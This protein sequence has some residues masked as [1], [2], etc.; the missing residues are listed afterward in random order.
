MNKKTLGGFAATAMLLTGGLVTGLP[1]T[2]GTV[3]GSTQLSGDGPV[4]SEVI[5]SRI[6][7]VKVI[8][9]NN[10]NSNVGWD[11]IDQRSGQKIAN[12]TMKDK[13]QLVRKAKIFE[14]RQYKLR[15]RCQDPIWNRTNC[16][17]SGYVATQ[18]D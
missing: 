17:A 14:G 7:N 4:Y 10:N 16:N 9:N 12:G 3:I 18:Y 13:G 5:S 8:I 15:L 6:T 11:L 1:A 2:A